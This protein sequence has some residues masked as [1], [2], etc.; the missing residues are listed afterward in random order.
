MPMTYDDAYLSV[1]LSSH[2]A[3]L[4]RTPTATGN[5]I[6]VSSRI[7]GTN[8]WAP[9]IDEAAQDCLD[10]LEELLK[11][12]RYASFAISVTPSFVTVHAIAR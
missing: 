11:E 8:D 5:L 9:A 10:Q 2:P 1:V 12:L 4:D 3:L 7:E 6:S